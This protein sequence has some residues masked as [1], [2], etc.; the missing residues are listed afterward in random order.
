MIV[1][2]TSASVVFAFA[3]S[4]R[5]AF[6]TVIERS[7]RALVSTPVAVETRLVLHSRRGQRAVILFDDLLRLPQFELVPLKNVV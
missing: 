1:V 3:E 6:L 4:A 2:D 5:E 7:K